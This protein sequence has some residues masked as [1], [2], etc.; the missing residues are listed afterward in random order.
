ME[1]T[2]E[3]QST[4]PGYVRPENPVFAALKVTAHAKRLETEDLLKKVSE[5]M[6]KVAFPAGDHGI[7]VGEYVANAKLA[8]R[9]LE[10]AK[11][12]IG[13]SIKALT[14]GVSIYQH[15]DEQEAK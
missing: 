8:Y 11:M 5:E 9:H 7:D 1:T 15:V 3:S 10:D 6:I 4:A 12:R 13:L 14:G 2:K